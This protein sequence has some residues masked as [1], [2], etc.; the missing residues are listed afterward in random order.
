MSGMIVPVF[1][2]HAG[3]SVRR[4]C[5]KA[6]KIHIG[7]LLGEALDKFQGS[8]NEKVTP[9][10]AMDLKDQDQQLKESNGIL[11]KLKDIVGSVANGV[12]KWLNENL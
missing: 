8:Q 7:T 2:L 6:A 4:I 12:A 1:V 10:M 3:L 5:R 9:E 11:G